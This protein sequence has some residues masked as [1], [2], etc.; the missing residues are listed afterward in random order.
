MMR[1]SRASGLFS[2]S[3]SLSS[4]S[5][6]FA[7]RYSALSS[8]S[9]PPEDRDGVFSLSVFGFLLKSSSPRFTFS[10]FAGAFFATTFFATFFTGFA[11]PSRMSVTSSASYFGSLLVIVLPGFALPPSPGMFATSLLCD[12]ESFGLLTEP[13]PSGVGSGCSQPGMLSKSVPSLFLSTLVRGS[14]SPSG[15]PNPRPLRFPPPIFGLLMA[16]EPSD[17]PIL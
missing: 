4:V 14:R 16:L 15:I 17:R 3:L 7:F 11:S 6:I 1:S 10:F 8:L 5:F 12:E 13:G 2:K 9:S